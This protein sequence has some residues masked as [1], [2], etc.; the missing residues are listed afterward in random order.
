M[1]EWEMISSGKAKN[2]K[3]MM[4][5]AVPENDWMGNACNK[6]GLKLHWWKFAENVTPKMIEWKILAPEKRHKITGPN[7]WKI[8][9]NTRKSH[10]WTDSLKDPEVLSV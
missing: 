1:T 7:D 2:L 5:N 8:T 6:K 3:E 9:E 4:G 10:S